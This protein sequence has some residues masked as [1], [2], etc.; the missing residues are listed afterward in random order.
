M[1][2]CRIEAIL[3]PAEG[4]PES[5]C[6]FWEPNAGGG[7]AFRRIDLAENL[8]VADWLLEMRGTLESLRTAEER[9]RYHALLSS[10][11]E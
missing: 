7:C 4:C 1:T 6:A 9:H 2:T 11:S 8:E 5:R 3:G 10:S